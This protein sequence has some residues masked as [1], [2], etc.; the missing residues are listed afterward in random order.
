MNRLFV[1]LFEDKAVRTGHIEHFFPK[2]EIKD[3]NVMIVEE[4]L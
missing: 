1:L 2:V 4:T 3:F